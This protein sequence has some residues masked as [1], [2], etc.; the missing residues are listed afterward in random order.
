MAEKDSAPKAASLSN[1][2][3]NEAAND[4]PVR[5]TTKQLHTQNHLISVINKLINENPNNAD[6]WSDISYLARE[7]NKNHS[8]IKLDKYGYKKF[9]DLISALRL[10]DMRRDNNAVLIKLKVK[11]SPL[12]KEKDS[13]KALS[14]NASEKLLATK[15]TVAVFPATPI[16]IEITNAATIDTVLFRVNGNEK[17]RG[18]E[19]MIFYGQTHSEDGSIELDQQLEGDQSLSTFSCDLNLQSSDIRQLNFTLSSELTSLADDSKL[20][21]IKVNIIN[22]QEDTVLFSGEFDATNKSAQTLLLFTLNRTGNQW[23]FVP[24]HQSIDGDLRHLCEKYGVELS[25]D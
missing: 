21:P 7:I 20:T 23:Q 24:K 8:N 1:R 25:N 11:K 12:T 14:N 4:T 17:V 16:V 3:L 19:D 18:D 13:K 9:S 10:Y 15:S 6:G 2:P 22:K 5:W